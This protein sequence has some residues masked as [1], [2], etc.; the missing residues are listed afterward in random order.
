M[1]LRKIFSSIFPYLAVLIAFAAGFG[2]HWYLFQEQDFP[3][4]DEAYN[5]V[6]NNGYDDLPEGSALEYGMIR[7]MIQAYGDP[8]TVFLE[9]AAA[10]L[11]GNSLHG[12]YG[13]IG[14]SISRD[15]EN[16]YI[17][18]PFPDGPATGAGVL[19]NDRLVSVDSLSVIPETPSDEIQAAI[20]GPVGSDVTIVIARPPAFEQHTFEVERR[21]I[22]L[23]SV[24]WH[25]DSS[26]ARLGVIQVNI[27]A[28]TTPD[29]IQKAVAD[30]QSRGATAFA[31]DLRNN[32]GGLL[33]AGID[34]ARLFLEDGEV[35][36]QQYRGRD[37]ETYEVEEPGPLA[38]IPLVVLVNQNTASAAEIIAGAIQA[39][40]RAPLI[41]HTTYGK[42]SIQLVYQ[43]SDTSSIHIT[44]AHWWFPGLAFP[45]D[46]HGLTP[47]HLLPVESTDPNDAIRIAIEILFP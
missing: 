39:H 3:I 20:R 34:I 2:L 32:G 4:L 43:L 5:I 11:E 37:V 29:E 33:D 19:E 9:P 27:I 46:G 45:V 13:G 35:I 16:N 15:L 14:V 26:E 12:S 30:L 40:G 6:K 38:D 31:L 1:I 8:H 21:E 18:L 25:L 41:G 28:D 10:E 23:P 36:Q 17:L 7:G 44:A 47:D 24:T 42:D 22:G